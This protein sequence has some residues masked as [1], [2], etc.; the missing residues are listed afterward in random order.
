M[1]VNLEKGQKVVLS[2]IGHNNFWYPSEYDAILLEQ[3]EGDVMAWI[4][5]GDLTPIK[6][7]SSLISKIIC[8]TENTVVWIHVQNIEAEWRNRHTQET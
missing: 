4:G 1:K 2:K 7:S 6:I 5:G 3:A 8:D